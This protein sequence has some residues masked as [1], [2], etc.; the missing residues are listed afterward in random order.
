MWILASSR[1]SE[2]QVWKKKGC[3]HCD[4]IHYRH[5]EA[6]GTPNEVEEKWCK[7]ISCDIEGVY[8]PWLCISRFLFEKIFSTNSPKC[9]WHQ[10]KTRKRKGPSRGIIQ[11]CAPRERSLARRNS[12]KDHIWRPWSKKDAR[13]KQHW[14]LRNISTSQEFGQD[15]VLYSYW[16]K[17][18][19]GTYFEKMRMMSKKIKLRRDGHIGKVLWYWLLMV[20]C[21][22]TR[23]HKCSFMTWISS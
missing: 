17:G 19:A 4:K 3:I 23:R 22:P 16:S 1:V 10:M 8:T 13:A 21:T 5:V 7:R 2:L 20:K 11:K 18:N 14:I 6:E 12:R 15:Y 9:T